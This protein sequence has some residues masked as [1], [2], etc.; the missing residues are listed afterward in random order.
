[1]VDSVSVPTGDFCFI[2]KGLSDIAIMYNNVSVPTG[3]FCFIYCCFGNDDINDIR[4][5]PHRGLLFYLSSKSFTLGTT[6]KI[7]SV[8]TGDFCFIYPV[9]GTP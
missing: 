2:Y 8:P 3:D 5:R 6:N 4:F 9:L 1:M 7:V